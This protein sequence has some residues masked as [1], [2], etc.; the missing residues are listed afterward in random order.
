MEK[1]I[2]QSMSAENIHKMDNEPVV[3]VRPDAFA[4]EQSKNIGQDLRT[5]VKK[6]LSV[7]KKHGLV[8]E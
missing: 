8:S 5:A 4:K 2:T 7:L 3:K 1:P 6:D